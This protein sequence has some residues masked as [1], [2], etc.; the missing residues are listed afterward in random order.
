MANKTVLG[1]VFHGEYPTHP[2]IE[3]QAL[4]L[5]NLGMEVHLFCVT[6][7]KNEPRHQLY[8]GIHVHRHYLPSWMYQLSALAYS[9]SLYHLI[10]K[11][12]L[13]SFVRD[14]KIDVLHLHNMYLAQP[15]F[16]LNKKNKLPIV[17][18][19]HENLPEIMKHYP[20][21]KSALGKVLIHPSFWKKKEEEFIKK[22]DKVIV[23]TNEAKIDIE[24]RTKIDSDKTLVL[25]NFTDSSFIKKSYDQ[26]IANR[27]AD[28]FNVLY[29]GDTGTRRGLESVIRSIP[30]LIH[31]IPNF[32]LIIV[33]SS[34]NDASLKELANKEGATKYVSAEGWQT[35][36][37]LPDYVHVA[38]VGIC[39]ILRNIHH[40]TTYANKLFQYALH[41]KSILASDCIA[42]KSLIENEEWGLIHSADDAVDF[43][44][45]LKTLY[46]NPELRKKTG[47]NAAKSIENKYNYGSS[48]FNNKFYTKLLNG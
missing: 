47:Q 33:G 26:N 7:K 38:D 46:H 3:N 17:L 15:L 40:D 20:H 19:L 13:G 23:V 14:N 42:Q 41:G 44:K 16:D 21:L 45:Q 36:N 31:D 4:H 34:S 12:K 43:A 18:D 5:I 1:M 37:L 6:Y 39:P 8:K 35:E 25:P 27:F 9:I 28:R 32:N 29:I 22:S 2:R 10:M 11:P 30:L 24:S 48:G